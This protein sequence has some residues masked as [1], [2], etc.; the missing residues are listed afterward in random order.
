[1][2]PLVG[3]CAALHKG[4]RAARP[5]M[6]MRGL[7]RSTSTFIRSRCSPVHGQGSSAPLAG[8]RWRSAKATVHMWFYKGIEQC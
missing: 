3:L 5:M 1:M 7:G 4:L 8:P 6:M 2:G